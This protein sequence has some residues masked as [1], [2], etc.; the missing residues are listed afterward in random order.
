MRRAARLLVAVATVGVAGCSSA[1]PEP[2]VEVFTTTGTA[3]EP[4][5]TTEAFVEDAVTLDTCVLTAP[6][7]VELTGDVAMGE[8]RLTEEGAIDAE[9]LVEVTLGGTVVDGTLVGTIEKA[10]SFSATYPLEELNDEVAASVVE[11]RIGDADFPA[12]CRALLLTDRVRF[13]AANEVPL[14]A[15]DGVELRAP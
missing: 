8:T 7:V 14:E 1:P 13:L 6:G 2:G 10:G 3:A 5:Y 11:S 12:G 4:T 15:A 9:L